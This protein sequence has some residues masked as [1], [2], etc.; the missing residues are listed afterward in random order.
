MKTL[1]SAFFALAVASV[2][3]AAPP[4]PAPVSDEPLTFH[5]IEARKAEL[6][7]QVVKVKV[8]RLLG[9]GNAIENGLV[10]FIAKDTS[11]SATPYGQIAFPKAGLKKLGL[12]DDPAKGPFQVYVRVHVF[13]EQASAAALSVAVGTQ[14]KADRGKSGSYSW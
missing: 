10:R 6:K 8:G 2:A 9:E 7:D 14:F 1:F 12:I 11:D 13:A 4:L 3:S 5:E